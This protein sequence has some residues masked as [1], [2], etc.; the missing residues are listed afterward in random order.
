MPLAI[1]AGVFLFLAYAIHE[2]INNLHKLEQARL[3]ME[4]A[5]RDLQVSD[6]SPRYKAEF[7][8][9]ARDYYSRQRKDR[10]LTVYDEQRIANDLAAHTP[11]QSVNVDGDYIANTLINYHPDH[12]QLL[13]TPESIQSGILRAIR[14]STQSSNDGA[15]LALIHEK[16]KAKRNLI[17]QQLHE[18]QLQG[19]IEIGNRSDGVL[20]YRINELGGSSA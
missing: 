16:V 9:A 13:T 14:Q 10:I 5:A 3:G 1:V 4:K 7:V 18:L 20:V 11:S 6:G 19:M 8:A 2:A 17:A 15:S 12:S